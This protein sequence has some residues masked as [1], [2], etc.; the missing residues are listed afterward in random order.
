[1][2]AH[3]ERRVAGDEAGRGRQRRPPGLPD[4]LEAEEVDRAQGA[5]VAGHSQPLLGATDLRRAGEALGDAGKAGSQRAKVRSK[6]GGCSS[7]SSSVRLHRAQLAEAGLNRVHRSCAGDGE[8]DSSTPIP[9][10]VPSTAEERSASTSMSTMRRMKK[11][12]KAIMESTEKAKDRSEAGGR[13]EQ[14]RPIAQ[15]QVHEVRR[16]DDPASMPIRAM[17]G[18]AD[19]VARRRCCEVVSGLALDPFA[20]ANVRAIDQGSRPG[21]RRRSGGSRSP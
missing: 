12:P 16:D 3:A 6:S 19:D 15:H 5:R 1:M 9:A 11:K 7:S 4:E 17:G 2:A 18:K 21:F 13:A 14:L 20:F 10:T 8:Q